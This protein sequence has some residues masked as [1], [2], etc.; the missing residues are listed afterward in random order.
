MSIPG[1]I[2]LGGIA[3]CLPALTACGSDG[4]R[5]DGLVVERGGDLVGTGG[6]LRVA[7]SV[8]GDIML[9][10]GEVTFSGAAGGDY[11]GAGGNQEISGRIHGS[12]R[13]AGGNVILSALVARNATIAGGNVE[14]RESAIVV[15]N[16]Y[17]A[18]GNVVVAGTVRQ[19]LRA[20]GGSVAISGSAGDVNVSANELRVG[21]RARIDGDLRYR[22]PAENVQIDSA[23]TITGQVIAEPVRDV[24]RAWLVFRLLWGLSFL[25]AGAVLVAVMPAIATTAADG[26]RAHAGVAAGFGVMWLL[27]VPIAMAVAA[28]TVI[29]IPLAMLLFAAYLIVMYL[30]GVVLALAIGR[31]ALG[32]RGR[33][34]RGPLVGAFLLGAVVLYALTWIPIVGGLVILFTIVLGSGGLLMPVVRRRAV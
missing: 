18:G 4:Q 12:A 13:A 17:L 10:G 19:L 26:V 27:L 11:L 5:V 32:D 24:S 9:S 23:A 28:V 21:P 15:G 7:D 8:S 2:L 16:A 34:G 31:L 33:D 1:R 22:V 6:T 25:A 29:G 20:T 3:C 30:A 14:V